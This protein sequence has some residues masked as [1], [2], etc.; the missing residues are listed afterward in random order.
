MSRVMTFL[1]NKR[2]TLSF[3]V[4]L[5]ITYLLELL[6]IP[7]LGIETFEFWFLFTPGFDPTPA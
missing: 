2:L 6:T 7:Q 5:L 1:S 4:I 3:I